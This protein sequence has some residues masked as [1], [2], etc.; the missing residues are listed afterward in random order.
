MQI[1]LGAAYTLIA[2]IMYIFFLCSALLIVLTVNEKAKPSIIKSVYIGYIMPF[3]HCIFY[4]TNT[5]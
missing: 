3:D 1:V 4:I 2:A 5:W